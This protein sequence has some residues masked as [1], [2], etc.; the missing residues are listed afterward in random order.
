MVHS[1]WYPPAVGY[2]LLVF[3]YHSGELFDQASSLK[4]ED[5]VTERLRR[6]AMRYKHDSLSG[7]AEIVEYQSFVLLVQSRGGFIQKQ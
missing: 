6:N 5:T 4:T 1:D 7:S 2:R 3:R